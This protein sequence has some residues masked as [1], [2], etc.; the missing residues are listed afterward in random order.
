VKICAALMTQNELVDLTKNV[1]L[2]LPHVDSITIVDGGSIDATIITMRNWSR[3]EPKIRFFIH[4]WKDNFPAQ[5]NN[6]LKHVGEIAQDGDWVLAVD[7][8]EFLEETAL[9]NLRRLADVV[10]KKREKFTRV[11]FRC[12]SVSMRGQERCWQNEDD[13][14]KGLFFR[15]S[16]AL[17]YTHHGEGAVHEVL[18][19]AD[20]IY[21]TGHHP[22]FPALVYEHVK[23]ENQ[24]WPR[25][26]RNYFIGG[27]GPNLGSKNH[28]WTEMKQIVAKLGITTWHQ[29][30]AYLL[31]GNIIGELRDWI[32]KYRRETGWDGSCFVPGQYVLSNIGARAVEEFAEDEI[33]GTQL[34]DASG[35]LTK[36]RAPSRKIYAGEV[37]TIKAIN[38]V[39]VTI[40]PEHPILVADRIPCRMT[41]HP[42]WSQDW[43]RPDCAQ[44]KPKYREDKRNPNWSGTYK[45]CSVEYSHEVRWIP[46]REVRPGQHCVLYPRV[47]HGKGVSNISLAEAELRGWYQAEGW[48]EKFCISLSVHESKD[49]IDRIVGLAKEVYPEAVISVYPDPERHA[50]RIRIGTG[51]T[52]A[53]VF[54]EEYGE[55]SDIK[56]VPSCVWQ[57]DEKQLHAFL[58]GY[59]AGDG[60]V[61]RKPRS[62]Y[63]VVSIATASSRL[64]FEIQHLLTRCGVFAGFS[65]TE[66]RTDRFSDKPMYRLAVEGRQITQMS[67]LGDLSASD[68]QS[69]YIDDRYFYLP[70]TAT[71]HT[72]Y[73]GPVFN[74]E[75]AGHTYL[76]AFVVHNSEQREHYK[77]YFR[78]WH[79]EEEPAELRN[80]AIE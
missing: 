35:K 80:E 61:M 38:T 59:I 66:A 11:G 56:H 54:R 21:M 42:G 48:S 71:E 65:K 37:I 75:T 5:R 31:A 53:E 52:I 63:D 79:P 29:M 12:R 27:G 6:Y 36:V 13:Y 50:A 25:G 15:W 24:T 33:V 34:F 76:A 44:S 1:T 43:C 73:A 58:R 23:Q 17:K 49:P 40:T 10:Y 16:T 9:Q 57:F 18:S 3:V 68:R 45:N 2:L 74:A 14:R 69:F 41:G 20:P 46:A 47:S 72:E 51:R 39:P 4:P 26:V 32:I 7:P 60:C 8:D 19:G 67:F 70:V 62:P 55:R 78:L 30:Q 77:T 28:R 64:A 22:E